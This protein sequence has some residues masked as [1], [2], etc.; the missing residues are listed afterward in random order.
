[1]VEKIIKQEIKLKTVEDGYIEKV[2]YKTSDG[3]EYIDKEHAERVQKNIDYHNM[4][5]SIEKVTN[6]SDFNLRYYNWYKPKNQEELDFI[7]KFLKFGGKWTTTIGTPVIGKWLS[8]YTE[9]NNTWDHYYIITLEEFLNGIDNFRNSFFIRNE[10][11]NKFINIEFN[12]MV[13]KL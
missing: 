10:E 11:E 9:E 8:G 3:N 13:K 4:Y 7:L 12:K 6:N 1:M 5:L 2:Y